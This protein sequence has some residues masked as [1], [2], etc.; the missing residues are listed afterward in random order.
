MSSDLVVEADD[1]FSTKHVE[2]L[3]GQFAV[4]TG[5]GSG[6]GKSVTRALAAQGATV[7]LIG[8]TRAKLDAT[9]ALCR[10]SENCS[11]LPA[12]LS[13]DQELDKITAEL[14]YRF[15][16]LHILVLSAGEM[17]CGHFSS[18][19]VEMFDRLYQT[20]VRA[21]FRLVQSLLPLLKRSHKFPGQIVFVNSSVALSARA[22]VAQYSAAQHA[23]KALADSLRSEVNSDGIRVLS[24]YPGRV[25]TPRQESLYRNEKIEYR[26]EILLQSEDVASVVLNALTLPRTAEVTDIT[27]RPFAKS[28]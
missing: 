5:A 21:N 14:E 11:I 7:V 22:N 1:T 25:A 17:A 9:A 2:P 18:A 19:P 6:I 27:I 20:N 13:S 10:N 15:G 8:R 16:E 12:D 4:V 3:S 28:Y 26:P 23:L 24:V